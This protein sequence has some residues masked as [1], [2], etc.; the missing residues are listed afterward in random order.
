MKRRDMMLKALGIVVIITILVFGLISSVWVMIAEVRGTRQLGEVPTVIEIG[1]LGVVLFG[2]WKI[3][4]ALFF[5]I[6][7]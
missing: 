7:K 3:I 4:S 1:N 5:D 2:C 6:R